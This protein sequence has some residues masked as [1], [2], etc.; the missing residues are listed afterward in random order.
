M[1]YLFNS[2]FRSL[3]LENALRT[4][5]LPPGATNEYRYKFRGARNQVASGTHERIK[6][7][8]RGDPVAITFID[9]YA[10]GGYAYHPLRL[11]TLVKVWE[12]DD[13]LYV[14]AQL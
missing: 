13:Y 7:A 1:W 10:S 2:G 4:L 8:R 3:Y 6:K 5:F 14:R 9:R 11:A 12:E